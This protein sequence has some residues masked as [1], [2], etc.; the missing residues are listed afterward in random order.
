MI[1]LHSF[2]EVSPLW[3]QSK[4]SSACDRRRAVDN[5]ITSLFALRMRLSCPTPSGS[6]PSA[7]S[8]SAYAGAMFNSDAPRNEPPRRTAFLL[9]H[10]EP[11]SSFLPSITCILHAICTA[12]SLSPMPGHPLNDIHSGIDTRSSQV[13]HFD[14]NIAYICSGFDYY[15]EDLGSPDNTRYGQVFVRR[16]GRRRKVSRSA[17]FPLKFT[18]RAGLE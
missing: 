4:E 5:F 13:G 18:D 15:Y 14:A 3:R 1:G 16:C 12:R 2:A 17:T 10:K 8:F 9:E 11:T 7:T 6:P